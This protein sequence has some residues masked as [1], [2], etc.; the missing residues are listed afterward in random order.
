MQMRRRGVPAA[1]ITWVIENYHTRRPAPPRDAALPAEI[2]LG[3]YEG[4]AL[5]VYVERGT[6]PPKV[7]TV[8]WEA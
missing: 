4:R 6:S 8:V 5:K 3:L 2:L 1:A 7:K